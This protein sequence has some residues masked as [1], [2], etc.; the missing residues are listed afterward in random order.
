M[1]PLCSS[2][3]SARAPAPPRTPVT[4]PGERGCSKVLPPLTH[5]R[6]W[7]GPYDIT[8][9]LC[10]TGFSYPNA[11]VPVLVPEPSSWNPMAPRV[12]RCIYQMRVI[13]GVIRWTQLTGATQWCGRGQD[14]ED[15]DRVFAPWKG[16]LVGKTLCGIYK[17][18]K[19]GR[20]WV[21][22]AGMG[23]TTYSG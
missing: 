16:G 4:E 13:Q 7:L 19:E 10:K 8:A 1:S 15:R 22:S 9:L 17:A 23:G 21:R 14:G 12:P 5:V 18:V 11:Y 3:P 2:Q 20:R 6:G